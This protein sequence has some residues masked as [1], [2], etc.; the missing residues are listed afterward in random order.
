MLRRLVSILFIVLLCPSLSLE[1][2]ER[3]AE[4]PNIL[5]ITVDT[6]RAD[7]VSALGYERRTSPSVDELIR[8]GVN[9]A[10]ARTVEPLTNPAMCSMFTSLAPHQHGATR[11]GLRL[12]PGLPSLPK[13]LNEH[14]YRTAAFVGSWTLKDEI[15]GLGEHFEHYEEVLSRKRW[16]GIWGREATARD[17]SEASLA[18][19]EERNGD[20]PGQPFLVWVHMVEPHAPY[21]LHAE[22][23]PILNRRWESDFSSSDRYDTEVAFA[24]AAIG[25][26]LERL[27]DLSP[28]ENTLI[29]FTSDHGESLGEHR[30]WGHGRHLYEPTLRIPMV[31]YWEGRLPATTIRAPSLITDLAP[32]ILRLLGLPALE[33]IEGYDW[34]G[35]LAGAPAPDGRV[36]RYEAHRGAV[37]SRNKS[38]HAR[39]AGLLEVGL[40]QGNRKEIYRVERGRR[41][42]FDLEQDP[43][44]LRPLAKPKT[45]PS[46]P[47]VAWMQRVR[48]GLT[49]SDEIPFEGLDEESIA[50]LKALGYV[51]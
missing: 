35:V 24:D 10:Q 44:E 29:V 50:A 51:D 20:S 31:L 1:S 30:Y 41:Y 36:T 25:G 9:F 48:D 46:E 17:L 15:S 6:L 38:E 21:K 23:I 28:P 37:F 49:A 4:L 8:G 11:N 14:G 26:L 3:H 40:L 42:V 12:R 34:A 7:R 13:T 18:W 27:S 2:T 16:F 22:F 33:Q 5:V 19:I 32:T 43:R 47:L 39:R 45:G